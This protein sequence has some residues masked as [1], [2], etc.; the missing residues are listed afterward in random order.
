MKL[1]GQLAYLAK[2]PRGYIHA[3]Y[4]ATEELL[5]PTDRIITNID[6]TTH[7]TITFLDKPRLIADM[8][9]TSDQFLDMCILAGS[10]LSRTF[11]PFANDFSLK[12]I[13]DL[14]KNYK[15]GI[16][17]CQA[18]RQDNQV[19]AHA[20]IDTFMRARLAVKYSLV[21]T[22]EGNCVPLPMIIQPTPP[23]T[24]AD[25]PA[26]FDEI[27]SLRL[28]DEL[29]YHICKGLI[30]PQVV[31]W[32]TSGMVVEPQPLADSPE[33]RRFIKDVI[34]EGHTAPR[35]TTLGLLTDA[36]HPQWKQRRVVSQKLSDV[37]PRKPDSLRRLPTITTSRHTVR[38][39]A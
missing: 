10:A 33:Y 35:C 3:M 27:F 23:V 15:S 30:S 8:G 5:W 17:V 4:T 7:N 32:L 36:L 18:W 37:W 14:V 9:L 12:T 25:V 2:H 22:T 19:K 21:L 28:P 11:P 31:G 29:Y 1:I 34:T 6:W 13:L 39:K 16:A 26:D 20:Y 38:L 24:T